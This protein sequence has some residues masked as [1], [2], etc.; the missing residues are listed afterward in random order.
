MT[1]QNKVSNTIAALK[2][3]PTREELVKLLSEELVIVTFDK[4]NGDK[5]TM[6]CTLSEHYIPQEDKDDKLSQTR[7]RNLEDRVVVV[8]DTNAKGWR[9]FRYDR[10]NQVR[11]LTPLGG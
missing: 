4:L 6:V 10:V 3:I 8:W 7:I 2:G 9:S 1:E 5:R 11:Q